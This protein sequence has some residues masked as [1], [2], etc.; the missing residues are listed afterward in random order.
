MKRH[1]LTCIA[2][3]SAMLGAMAQRSYT[4]NAV[5]FNVD[6]LPNSILGIDV[7]PDG[8]EAAGATELCGILANSGWD[9]AGISED[10][11]FHNYL[12]AAPAS[13]YYNFGE[14]GGSVSG[15][16]NSTDGLG[17]ACAKRLTMSGGTRVEWDEYYGETSDGSDGMITK[18]FRVYNVTFATG[19]TVD[20]YVLHMDASDGPEDIAARETQLTQLATYIKNNHN[21]RPVI[22]LGDTNCRYTREQLKTL[23]IDVINADSRFTIEDAWVELMW[24]G[25]YPTYGGEAMMTH[26]YGMQKGEIVDKVFYIN[27]TASN[28]T[29]KANSY[30]HDESV[31]V[32][33]H[34]PVVVNF[35][36]TDP[37]G[38]PITDAWKEENW[39]FEETVATFQKPSWKG[40]QVEDGTTY[41]V[42]NV[43]TGRY[44]KW[45]GSWTASVVTG[46]A[47][48]PVTPTLS[49]GK[50]KLVTVASEGRSI[51]HNLFMDNQENKTWTLTPVS[52]TPNHYYIENESGVIAASN[53]SNAVSI[54][55]KNT[56]DDTQKWI[57][58]TEAGMIAAMADANPDYP[59]N[60]T[61]MLGAA[62]F[63]WVDG[64]NGYAKEHWTN[65][66]SKGSLTWWQNPGDPNEYNYSAMTINTA[67]AVTLSQAIENLPAG[68]YKFSFEGF[69]NY[70]LTTTTTKKPAWG[71]ATTSTETS[72]Q[73]M[74]ATVTVGSE[75]FTLSPNR[76]VN[77]GDLAAASIAFRDGDTYMTTTYQ[78]LSSGELNISIAKPATPESG[79]SSS[80]SWG[81]TTTTNKEYSNSVHF[82][83]F[84]LEY[85]GTQTVAVD[86]Y[87]DYKEM[88]REKVNETYPLVMALNAAG[89]AAYD[90]TVVIERYNND[91]ITTGAIAQAMCDYVDNAYANALAAHDM[92]NV[93]QAIDQMTQN[94]G[95][96]TG[97]IINPS[98]ETG[99]LTGWTVDGGGWDNG[100]REQSNATFTT[101]GCDGAY[102]FN[103]YGGDNDHTAYVKQTIKGVPNGLYELKVKVTSFADRYV[104]ITGN[105]YH[106]KVATTQDKGVF[107]EATLY[108]LV[109]DGTATIG[110]V[111]GNKGGG[112]EF[113]HYWPFQGC[114]FKADNFRLKYICDVPHGRLKLALDEANATKLDGFGQ[115][116][117]DLSSYQAA[118]DNKSLTTDGKAEV[119]AIYDA[120]QVAAKAQKTAGADMTWAIENPS[121]E[122]GDYTGWTVTAIWDTGAF[123]QENG[124]YAIA[125]TDGRYMFN[126]WDAGKGNPITQTVTGIPN[127]NYKLTA[128]VATD[129]D[130]SVTLTGNGAS[131][132]I[133]ASTNGASSGVFPE[134]ECTVSDGTLAITVEGA[135]GVWYKCDDFHLTL[136]SPAETAELVFNHAATTITAIEDITFPRVVLQRPIKAKDS[137]GNP[138]WSS[139]VAPFDIP[140][141]DDWDYMELSGATYKESSGNIS[142]QFTKVETIE[143]GVPYMVR[144]TTM[145]ETLPQI[146]MGETSVNTVTMNDTKVTITGGN[147]STVT[148]KGVY[149]AGNVPQGAFFISDNTFYQAADGTNTLKGFRGYI[150]IEGSL[151]NKARSMSFRW[152]DGTTSIDNGQLT[153]DNEVT[154]VAIYNERGMRLT[155][156]QQ[157][158]NI[159]LMSDGT[160]V[161]VEIR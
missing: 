44:V 76:S 72:E 126:I 45:G 127:G 99:D 23:F 133:A 66:E 96:I 122:T 140:A 7:N 36:L 111:G 152:D 119:T 6:G 58:L 105:G 40:E 57:F 43:G 159:L 124:T 146:E 11:N 108:F 68:N 35:T 48:H 28:L 38:T 31:T 101:E 2:L 42:M 64:W 51:G 87:A 67:E 84:R 158:I 3:C 29:L 128:M 97:A 77:V 142:L 102:L 25:T 100:A 132:T 129:A 17:F 109:E 106:S 145:T 94:G 123:P 49:D 114:F 160:T 65:F 9:F 5:A 103:S 34:K 14:H 30:L 148:F 21:N 73:T 95:D 32:S 62:D 93:Q 71:N 113:I 156:M 149:T 143:A 147:G 104:Y 22:I 154:T 89:Q 26:T 155:E 153:N 12:T 151:A 150:Q 41:Y 92:Y 33:D 144:C 82:D 85:R 37:S 88:V 134:V 53:N 130:K 52:G 90:I 13:T 56:S 74:N 18:G 157:G 70:I 46:Y 69:Y 110:A 137:K 27:T 136:V 81:T 83:N 161:K 54:A 39:Q 91:Q 80:N 115:I 138:A 120:L 75:T 117:L 24:G 60:F 135:D 79:S 8:K 131:T 86:P 125:G 118:Y 63:D 20:V 1:L 141:F 47:G 50:Y 112:T 139:F 98:F 116:A 107:H 55:T 10:F 121:F 16:S 59:F 19:V 15:L 78:T 61:P 4:F